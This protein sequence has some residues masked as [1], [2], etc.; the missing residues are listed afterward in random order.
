[1][2]NTE[3][4]MTME[5]KNFRLVWSDPMKQVK[6]KNVLIHQKL[7]K[8]LI[9]ENLECA[10]VSYS[11]SQVPRYMVR[12]I[13][14]KMREEQGGLVLDGVTSSLPEVLNAIAE[15]CFVVEGVMTFGK[16]DS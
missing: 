6:N 11:I 14:D 2:K 7:N 4:M 15:R 1:M 3:R 9:D 12:D 16:K 13:L 8:L 5:E 10:S